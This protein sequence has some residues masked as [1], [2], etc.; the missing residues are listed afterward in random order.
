MENEI[1]IDNQ[2][3]PVVEKFGTWKSDT[4]PYTHRYKQIK[5]NQL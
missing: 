1:N 2:N 4:K 5:N 3:K